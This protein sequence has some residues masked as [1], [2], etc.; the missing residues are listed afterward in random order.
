M[1]IDVQVGMFDSPLIPPVYNGKE[2]LAKVSDLIRKGRSAGVPIIYIQ[3]NGGKGH[4]LEQGMPGWFI[5]PSIAPVEGDAVIQK[6][7]SDSF[8]NTTLQQELERRNITKIVV[9]GI[10]TDY[11][12]D[13]TCRCA[14]S[15]GYDITLVKD[16][17]STWG[18]EILSASQ[19]IAH[20]NYVLGDSFVTLKLADDIDFQKI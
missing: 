4:P 11:C 18:T 13:T 7:K 8:Y 15:L 9:A 10:Q 1:I 3:H 5:H 6:Q 14:H 20:H 17:H 19:I 12:V 16:A 2:L